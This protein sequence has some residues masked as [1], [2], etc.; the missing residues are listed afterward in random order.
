MSTE[1]SDEAKGSPKIT[2]LQPD[3]AEL[4][5]DGLENIPIPFPEEDNDLG[6]KR[7]SPSAYMREHMQ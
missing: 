2:L 4:G 3:G 1:D 6:E 5:D 7:D